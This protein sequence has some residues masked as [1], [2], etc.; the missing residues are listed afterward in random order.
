MLEAQL[1][2]KRSIANVTN[3]YHIYLFFFF[4]DMDC[5][6]RGAFSFTPKT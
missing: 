2:S 5:F 3:E 4:T 6:A 1:H